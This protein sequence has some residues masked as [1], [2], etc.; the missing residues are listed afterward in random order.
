MKKLLSTVL[1]ALIAINAFMLQE[2]NAKKGKK[3]GR[4]PECKACIEA[5]GKGNCSEQ[6]K[7]S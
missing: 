6:C 3:G 2:A 5:N 1:V 4:S 7:K